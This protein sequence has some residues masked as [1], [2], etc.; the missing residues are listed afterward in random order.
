MRA[1]SASH[2]STPLILPLH[3]GPT[4]GDPDIKR[5]QLYTGS[6]SVE[7]ENE[8]KSINLLYATVYAVVNVIIS[9]PGKPG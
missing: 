9:V 8:K 6:T 3:Q 5:S 7:Q 2:E 1:L 4:E